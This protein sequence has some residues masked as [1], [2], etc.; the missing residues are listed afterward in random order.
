MLAAVSLIAFAKI[1]D[2]E[3]NR[4]FVLQRFKSFL[5]PADAKRGRG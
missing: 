4:A 5:L 2:Y 1:G 3:K